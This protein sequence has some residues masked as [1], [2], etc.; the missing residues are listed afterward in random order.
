MPA[1]DIEQGVTQHLGLVRE[2]GNIR[3]E[4]GIFGEADGGKQAPARIASLYSF[5]R[6]PIWI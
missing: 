3:R 5:S 4:V 2:S 1:S 6:I